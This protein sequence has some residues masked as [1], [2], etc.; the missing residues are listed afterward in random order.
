MGA[1]RAERLEPIQAG[2]AVPARAPRRRGPGSRGED[3]GPGLEAGSGREAG[4]LWRGWARRGRGTLR[5]TPARGEA[6][7]RPAGSPGA[8]P[9]THPGPGPAPSGSLGSRCKQRDS[10]GANATF[11]RRKRRGSHSRTRPSPARAI[12]P[13]G[14]LGSGR[15]EA[16]GSPARPAHRREFPPESRVPGQLD[17]RTEIASEERGRVLGPGRL[18]TSVF[19][20][21][22]QQLGELGFPKPLAR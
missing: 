15:S 5:G 20:V 2:I 3:S 4:L 12:A 9:A 21:F 13:G 16:P 8:R 18:G 22:L 11:V 1:E 17:R 10:A 7:G 19:L 14:P 6:G